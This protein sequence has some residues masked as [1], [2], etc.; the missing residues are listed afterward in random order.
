MTQNNLANAYQVTSPEAIEPPIYNGPSNV[1]KRRCGFYTEQAFP[2]QWAM[3]QN[4]LATA[5]RNIPGGDRAA[6][7]QRA[8][9]CYEAAL[10]VYTEQAFPQEYEVVLN[11]LESTQKMLD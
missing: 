9:E 5:Y 11:G 7:I 3:T 6:N 2:Q 4:N 1:M 10:R 8:I